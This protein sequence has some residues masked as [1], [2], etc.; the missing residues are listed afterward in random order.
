MAW[1]TSEAVCPAA[2]MAGSTPW[3]PSIICLPVSWPLT[4][5]GDGVRAAKALERVA[6]FERVNVEHG[7]D[8][9]GCFIK[10]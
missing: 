6:V 7:D 5:S 8:S 1:V 10:V 9:D 2:S 3:N 4:W